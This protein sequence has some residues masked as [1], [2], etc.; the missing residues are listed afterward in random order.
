MVFV[1]NEKS[2][3]NSDDHVMNCVNEDNAWRVGILTEIPK[4]GWGGKYW[5]DELR[6]SLMQDWLILLQW[7]LG[8]LLALVIIGLDNGLAP[9]RCQ[10]IIWTNADLQCESGIRELTLVEFQLI[11]RNWLKIMFA[12]GVQSCAKKLV[13]NHMGYWCLKLC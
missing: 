2:Y 6:A 13:E 8:F 4:Q 11:S 9:N 5:R 7:C 3:L 12:I 10:A 1:Y